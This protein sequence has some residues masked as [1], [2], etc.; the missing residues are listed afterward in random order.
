M[1]Q[2]VFAGHRTFFELTEEEQHEATDSWHQSKTELPLHHFLGVTDSEYASWIEGDY[3]ELSP[4]REVQ[5]KAKEKGWELRSVHFHPG[6]VQL[7]WVLAD[8][9]TEFLHGSGQTLKEALKKHQFDTPDFGRPEVLEKEGMSVAQWREYGKVLDE[10]DTGR[11]VWTDEPTDF[12]VVKLAGRTWYVEYPRC[13]E[14]R[15]HK[16]KGIECKSLIKPCWVRKDDYDVF[17]T[18]RRLDVHDALAALDVRESGDFGRTAGED[19]DA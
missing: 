8:T 13:E 11:T 2:A 7:E 1:A 18:D 9:P 19:E 16:Q 12:L 17:L 3:L 4:L 5:K 15:D 6:I 10:G 14:K